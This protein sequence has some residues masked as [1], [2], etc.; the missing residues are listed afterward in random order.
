MSAKHRMIDAPGRRGPLSGSRARRRPYYAMACGAASSSILGVASFGVLAVDV[1]VLGKTADTAAVFTRASA[2][3]PPQ[4]VSQEG[5]LIAVSADSVTARSANGH[6]RSYRITPNTTC[7][8]RDGSRSG[9]AARHLRINEEVDIV[10][11]A[12]GGTAVATVV[13]D[14]GMGH[15]DGSPMD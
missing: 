9:S 2:P 12:Q 3:P 11:T 13:A 1:G 5:T 14:R 8:T 10:G 6:T 15:G 4:Q 7:V